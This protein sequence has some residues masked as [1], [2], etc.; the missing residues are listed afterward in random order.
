VP[1]GF[2]GSSAAT[3]AAAAVHASRTRDARFQNIVF[4]IERKLR[5]D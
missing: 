4:T 5:K 3:N 2:L 1:G